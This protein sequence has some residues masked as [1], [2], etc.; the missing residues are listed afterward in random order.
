MSSGDGGISKCL[1]R[2]KNDSSQIRLYLSNS[3]VT[4]CWH[5][6]RTN[7]NLGALNKITEQNKLEYTP[8]IQGEITQPALGT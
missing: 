6:Q 7:S 4:C 8:E 3:S 1:F 2:I 5:E